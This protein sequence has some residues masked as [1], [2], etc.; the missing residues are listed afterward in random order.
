MQ[1]VMII[2]NWK[3]AIY[4]EALA[5]GFSSLGVKVFKFSYNECGC[6]EKAFNLRYPFRY[7]RSI[8]KINVNI[9][10]ACIEKRP[11]MIFFYRGAFILPST[12]KYIKRELPKKVIS[13]YHNDNPFVYMKNRLKYFFFLRSLQ[14]SDITYVYRPSN[15][16]DCRKFKAVNPKL[17]M[18]HYCTEHHW[19]DEKY[20][21]EQ[22]IY[23]VVFTGHYEEDGRDEYIDSIFAAGIDLHVFG[24]GWENIFERRGWPQ[25]NCHDRLRGDTYRATINQ[26]KI[27]L[28][29]L[30]GRHQDVY[31]RRCFEIPASGTA[32]LLPDTWFLREIFPK[33]VAAAYYSNSRSMVANIR[34]LLGSPKKLEAM[35]RKAYSIAQNHN[36]KARAKQIIQDYKQLI[37]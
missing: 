16:K 18:S 9:V 24:R 14:Y 36:E 20:N 5:H 34:Q 19:W 23:D 8:K 32:M 35:T 33:D 13:F 7:W 4:E 15:L 2:G 25:A 3:W 1:S 11:S 28:V 10:R 30:S 22:K 12:V 6:E 17:L 37:H 27:V 29:F 21:L 31:T 26:A